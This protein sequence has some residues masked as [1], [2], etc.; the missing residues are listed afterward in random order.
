MSWQVANHMQ[1]M[2]PDCWQRIVI[3]FNASSS[4]KMGRSMMKRGRHLLPTEDRHPCAH[5]THTN[6]ASPH[7]WARQNEQLAVSLSLA[8]VISTGRPCPPAGHSWRRFGN[9]T[10]TA[11]SA[12]RFGDCGCVCLCGR[13]ETYAFCR[14]E[15]CQTLAVTRV[16]HCR[17]AQ[18]KKKKQHD[19]VQEMPR[20]EADSVHHSRA[21]VHHSSRALMAVSARGP[22]SALD[23]GDVDRH[24]TAQHGWLAHRPF[25]PAVRPKRHSQSRRSLVVMLTISRAPR[26]FQGAGLDSHCQTRCDG[27]GCQPPV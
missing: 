5:Q 2:G 26:W 15:T 25:F 14:C 9:G 13:G 16:L 6:A 21:S 12:S 18:G 7:Q 4:Q 22:S 8:P 27:H 3:L 11:C 20:R 19:P 17:T 24:G 23:T 1:A 10:A